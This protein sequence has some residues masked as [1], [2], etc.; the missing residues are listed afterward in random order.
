[1]VPIIFLMVLNYLDQFD[2]PVQV[3]SVVG[4]G[5]AVDV[6]GGHF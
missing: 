5:P 4:V 3:V 6:Q 1:M 2:D